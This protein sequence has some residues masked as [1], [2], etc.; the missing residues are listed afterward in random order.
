MRP[1]HPILDHISRPGV[2]IAIAAGLIVLG[3]AL[4]GL[5]LAN[6][7]AA[8]AASGGPGLSIAVVSPPERD[9]VPGEVMEV[10]QLTNEF[11]GSLPESRPS[12]DAP[13]DYGVEQPAYVEADWDRNP[14]PVR[15]DDERRVDSP[16]YD[17]GRYDRRPDGPR[18]EEVADNPR[19]FGFDAPRPDYRAEREARRAAMD[20]RMAEARYRE[21]RDR[22]DRY[23]EDREV[24]RYRSS[25]RDDGP[26]PYE[27]RN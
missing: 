1:D 11:D 21:D 27:D 10:G 20:A 3:L 5:A 16:R 14:P 2:R 4:G 12:T 7:G 25:G 18:P 9:V 24:R 15:R 13:Y 6:R 17:N 22:D 23:R 8:D 26:V 19:A